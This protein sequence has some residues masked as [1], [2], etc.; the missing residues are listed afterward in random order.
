MW[1]LYLST[2][3]RFEIDDAITPA[4]KIVAFW[5]GDLLM[6]PFLYAKARKNRV[7]CLI[8]EHKDGRLISS[9]VSLF[10]IETIAG[11]SSKGGRKSVINAL[12]VLR[13][14]EDIAI[15]PDGPRGPFRS[16]AEGIVMI[17]QKSGAEILVFETA[18]SKFW[19]MKSW[20]RFVIPKPFCTI[21]Y[22]AKKPFSLVGLE[23]EA[24]LA[25]V[26]KEMGRDDT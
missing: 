17:A 7:H 26:A 2:R 20:D 1:F 4:P 11:S 14:G 6:Q 8:S 22:R 9:V 18:P 10:G 25:L 12:R 15:T 24:A 16:I 3:A 5:H 21:T 23:K 19:R 13:E